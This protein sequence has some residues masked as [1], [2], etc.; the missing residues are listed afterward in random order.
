LALDNAHEGLEVEV[1]VAA[2]E[3]D[4]GADDGQL[5][6]GDSG[7]VTLAVAGGPLDEPELAAVVELPQ[8]TAADAK[9]LAQPRLVAPGL[10]QRL[11]LLRLLSR[12]IVRRPHLRRDASKPH[13]FRRR[14]GLH[15]LAKP[16]GM[17]RV[18]PAVG[19]PEP[20]RAAVPSPADHLE[21]R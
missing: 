8:L 19:L 5:L 21:R 6:L 7:G 1:A 4:A 17:L 2:A 11:E 10:Q 9:R 12:Q 18:R 16:L 15:R 14:D 13:R 3:A 20:P